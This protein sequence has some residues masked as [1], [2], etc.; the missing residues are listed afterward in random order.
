MELLERLE[1][2]CPL[3]EELEAFQMYIRQQEQQQKASEGAATAAAAAG[4]PLRDVEAAMLPLARLAAVPL[5]IRVVRFELLGP[6]TLKELEE[7]LDLVDRA[8]EQVPPYCARCCCCCCF[9]SPRLS[10]L[11]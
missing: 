8:T 3:P 5:K 6:K 7:A 2:V 11:P 9:L 4:P 10:R 1:Q